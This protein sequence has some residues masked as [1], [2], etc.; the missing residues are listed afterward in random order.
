MGGYEEG[1]RIA[2]QEIGDSRVYVEPIKKILD[3]G[4]ELYD[5][6]ICRA[7]NCKPIIRVGIYMYHSEREALEQ[8]AFYCWNIQN[9]R[10]IE[11]KIAA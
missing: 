8:G 5:Y 7:D 4:K 9:R 3:D 6:L 2:S 1:L 11:E 10:L